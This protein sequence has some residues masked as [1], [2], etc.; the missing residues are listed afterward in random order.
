MLPAAGSRKPGSAPRI[1]AAALSVAAVS[2]ALAQPGQPPEMS[3]PI[4]DP[5]TR[6]MEPQVR[7]KIAWARGLVAGDPRS[8]DAWGALGRTLQAHGLEPEADEAYLRAEEFGPAD[9]RWPY[10]RA[11]ALRNIRP[12]DALTAAGRAAD[13]N[14]GYAPIHL[15]AAELLESAGRADAAMDRYRQA[16]ETAPDSAPAELGIGRLLLRRGELEAARE[17]LER[18]AAL[19]PRA[20]P[21]H[22]SL[23]RLYARQGDAGA[24]RAAAEASRQLPDLV[25]VDDPVLTEVWDEAVSAQGYQQRALR[26][27]AAGDFEAAEA[28]YDHLLGLQPDDPDILY[29][30]GNLYVRT[31]RF[32]EA[33]KRYEGALA[34]RP[35]HVAARV[36]LGSALLMLGRRDEATDHLLR[37][38]E[39]DPTDPDANR[40][41]G[42]L[43]AYRGDN[44]AAIRH[45]RA[46]LARDPQD[47]PVHRDLAIVLAAEGEFA[48]AWEH[49]EAAERLGSPPTADFLLRLQAALPRP[50]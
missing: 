9:F 17:R 18:A 7:E 33:A 38:L 13:R 46:V 47:G 45:Y 11:T 5:D 2:G 48:T 44:E 28:L 34:A 27:E 25:P 37:A 3:L 29:N 49:V 26:A 19:A 16:L 12:E 4:P 8:A 40:T 15:L 43:F 23:A 30:F 20:G 1:L 24:A 42:G 21:V 50:R 10:L 14:P 22:A 6:A 39:D 31:R 32:G 41:L 35:E 36:N